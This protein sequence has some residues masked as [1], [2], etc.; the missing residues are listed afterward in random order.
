MSH[1]PMNPST[2]WT[3]KY[4]DQAIAARKLKPVE[5]DRFT[6]PWNQNGGFVERPE[7]FVRPESSQKPK[8]VHI[9]VTDVCNL[10]CH[11][12][13]IWMRNPRAIGELGFDEWKNVVTNLYK[14]LG[15][16]YV[17]KFAGGEPFVK[18]WLPDLIAYGK[19]LDLYIGVTTNGSRL[20][21]D[22]VYRLSEMGLDEVNISLDALTPAI[23]DHTRN[24]EG[25]HAQAIEALLAFKEAGVTNANVSTIMMKPN[26]DELVDMAWWVKETG[27]ATFTVQPILQNFGEPYNAKWYLT[28]PLWPDDYEKVCGVIEE[29]RAFR[30]RHWVVGNHD[31]QLTMMK[32]YFKNPEIQPP[33]P[34]G[35]GKAEIDIDPTGKM[36]LCFNLDFVGDLTKQQP[37]EVFESDEAYK[38]REEIYHCSRNC[39]LLNCTM[40]ETTLKDLLISRPNKVTLE[41]A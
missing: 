15:G 22:L 20:K 6:A 14:W 7:A 9:S 33:E 5:G 25:S 11:H 18:K 38:R 40:A 21:R 28:S 31:S 41:A 30:K 13:D 27:L 19:S 26:L 16:P 39:Y 36:G 32:F 34:C 12:C 1:E 24:K 23:H 29:L 4:V 10:S 8:V 3:G 17:L 2:A 35:A 37:D